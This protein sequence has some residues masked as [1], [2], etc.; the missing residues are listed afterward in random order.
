[1]KNKASFDVIVIG[2]GSA[3]FSAIEAAVEQGASVCAIEQE[4]LG[5][6][7]PN[8]ACVPSKALLKAASVYRTVQHAR[9]FGITVGAVSHD[10]SKLM[11]YRGSVV[12]SITGG[13]E[14]GERY[15][16]IFSKLGV[17]VKYGKARFIDD[18][19][20]E[21]NGENIFGNTIVIATGTVDFIP[22]IK[23]IEQIPYKNWKEVILQKRQ[24]KSMAIIGGGPVGCELATFYA[25]FG[26]RVVLLQRAS[27][28]LH[29][30]DEEI[31]LLAFHSLV[32]IGI[33]V[34][35][36]VEVDSVIDSRGGVFGVRIR[37]QSG[38]EM[39]AVDQ[40]V[41]AA[42]KKANIEGLDVDQAGVMLDHSGYVK[43]TKDQRTSVHHIFAAGDV[44]G[45]LQF[46]HTAHHEGSVAGYNAALI[47]KKKRTSLKTT[48]ERVVPRV[49]FIPSEVAS[50]GM[51]QEQ[52]KKEYKQ[53]LVGRWPISNLGRAVTENQRF[54]LLKIIA[55]PK[56]RKVIGGHVIGERAGEVIHEI[57]LAMFLNTTI[58]K[59]SEMIH[60]FPTYSEA[61][62]GAAASVVKE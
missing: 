3:G 60:A 44:D 20:I 47:A 1:M 25:T 26:T 52:A 33:D 38:L 24:P 55:H 23:D 49:T 31:A 58:D 36:N 18:H 53:V 56:T 59:L 10:F 34:R 54:G 7:C 46:T 4:K 13:G 30:E 41:L 51:T 42:G 14:Y 21:V 37:N 15:K 6:E 17:E 28:V 16:A 8:F 35:L 2:T 32:D 9:D 48:N 27:Q 5:G 12:D 61:I 29:R 62:A 39:I 45:G 50:V 22:P 57:A 19:M 40:V 43:T 11:Q